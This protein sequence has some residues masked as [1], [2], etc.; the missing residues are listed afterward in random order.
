MYGEQRNNSSDDLPQLSFRPSHFVPIFHH[1]GDRAEAK[2]YLQ[3]LA[4]R[5]IP[6]PAMNQALT[7]QSM[8]SHYTKSVILAHY[9]SKAR[10]TTSY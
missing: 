3:M 1:V 9:F 10:D 6:T 8:A 2:T 7:V 5:N 4:K